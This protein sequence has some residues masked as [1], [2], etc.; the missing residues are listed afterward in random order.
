LAFENRIHPMARSEH[1]R[2]AYRLL[3][4]YLGAGI[5]VFALLMILVSFPIAP[6]WLVGGL[7]VFVVVTSVWSWTRYDSNFMMPSLVGTMAAML[8]MVLVGVGVGL[9]GWF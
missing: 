6:T 3:F 9:M 1:N 8:W 4:G 2:E 5:Q 7:A